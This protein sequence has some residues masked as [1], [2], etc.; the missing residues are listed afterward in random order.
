[1]KQ[2]QDAAAYVV[3]TRD[4]R[5]AVLEH[6]AEAR[7]MTVT[8]LWARRLRVAPHTQTAVTHESSAATEATIYV[9]VHGSARMS[10]ESSRLTAQICGG[11]SAVRRIC[12]VLIPDRCIDR[13]ASTVP[14]AGGALTS[15]QN[16]LSL[17]V[18]RHHCALCQWSDGRS[19]PAMPCYHM[20][21]PGPAQRWPGEAI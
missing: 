4:G 10:H 14:C 16:V 9:Y 2:V 20:A 12:L 21:P 3:L 11:D 7:W 19:K 5:T 13:P 18:S 15:G 17:P 6:T 1:M 8:C